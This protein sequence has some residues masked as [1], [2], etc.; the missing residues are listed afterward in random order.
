M[1]VMRSEAKQTKYRPL[2]PYMDP[3]A[4]KDYA[5][6]WKQIVTLFVRM[7]GREQEGPKYW[8]R[9]PEQIY[10]NSMIKRAR[11]VRSRRI[12]REGRD[13]PSSSGSG[14]GSGSASSASSAGTRSSGLLDQAASIRLYGL[15]AACLRF[16][17][18]LLACRCRG[19]EY[20]LPMIGTMS[21]LAI[22]PE[23]WR[24]ASEY[25]PMISHI[26]KMARFIIIQMAF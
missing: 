20:E 5:R 23:G 24:S 18:A 15:H 1:E 22:K 14:S 2:Q 13:R 16:Y 4:I 8:F 9:G 26:I 10:F 6:P 25:P 11:R 17:L 3:N 21:V 7:R 12:T 19:H